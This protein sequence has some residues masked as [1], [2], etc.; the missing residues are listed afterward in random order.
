M[1]I[2]KR[3]IGKEY[4]EKASK[5]LEGMGYTIIDRNFQCHG[6]EIDIVAREKEYLVFIEVKFRKTDKMGGPWESVD[7]RKQRVISKV[8]EYY[9][10]RHGHSFDASYRFDVVLI[11]GEKI[12][13]IKNAFDA[14]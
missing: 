9:I 11:L 12:K 8:A 14:W 10:Y 2:N 6:G 13:L 5:Y 7:T 4:E 1:A 3:R